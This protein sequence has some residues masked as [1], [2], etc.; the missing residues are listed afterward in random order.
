M[1][2]LACVCASLSIAGLAAAQTR[3][4]FEVAS[5]KPSSEQTTSINIGVRISGSQ[6]RIS[7]TSLR[8]YIAMAYSVRSDQIVGPDWIG[9]QRFDIAAKIPD[10]GSSNQF[11]ELMQSLLSERFGLSVHRDKKDFPIYALI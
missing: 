6:V 3:P 9:Q 8:D 4:E 1:R 10:G 2:I 11:A 5:I 7:Y